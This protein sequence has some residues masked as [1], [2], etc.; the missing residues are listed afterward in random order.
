MRPHSQQEMGELLI[1]CWGRKHIVR[2][3]GMKGFLLSENEL[4]CTQYDAWLLMHNS[5]NKIENLPINVSRVWMF[6][7]VCVFYPK[8]L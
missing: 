3:F 6:V 2:L 1:P 5:I 7:C 8:D 4:K